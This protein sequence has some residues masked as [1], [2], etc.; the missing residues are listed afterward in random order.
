MYVVIATKPVHGAP[1]ANE[2]SSAQLEGTPYFP[3][4]YTRVHAVMWECGEGQTD[5][6]TGAQT[7]RRPWPIYISLRLCLTRNVIRSYSIV[8]LP[9]TFAKAPR[10][11][12]YAT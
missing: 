2:P 8:S 5:T 6:Q 11:Q 4:S 10:L 1:F 7:H 12:Q 9:W 3:P